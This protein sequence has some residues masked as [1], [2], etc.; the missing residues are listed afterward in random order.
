MDGFETEA[1]TQHYSFNQT[2]CKDLFEQ[3]RFCPSFLS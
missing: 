3:V 2:H 1:G